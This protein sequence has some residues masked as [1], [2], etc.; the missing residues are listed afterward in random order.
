MCYSGRSV[1]CLRHHRL[2]HI[3]WTEGAQEENGARQVQ[4]IYV[5]LCTGPHHLQVLWHVTESR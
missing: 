4:M 1:H 3:P 5:N 2:V